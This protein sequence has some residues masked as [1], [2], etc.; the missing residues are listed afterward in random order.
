MCVCVYVY[1]CLK[2]QKE[3]ERIKQKKTAMTNDI[4]SKLDDFSHAKIHRHHT[5]ATA[6]AEKD[7][8]EARNAGSRRYSVDFHSSFFSLNHSFS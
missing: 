3:R 6:R 1:V 5:S 7:D 2:S 8:E 4:G